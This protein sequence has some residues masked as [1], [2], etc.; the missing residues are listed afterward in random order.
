LETGALPI[1]LHS[2]REPA[3]PPIRAV[4][5]IGNA[6]IARAKPRNGLFN[7]GVLRQTFTKPYNKSKREKP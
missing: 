2:Y 1:E 5:S 7:R 4:S 6:P 3:L